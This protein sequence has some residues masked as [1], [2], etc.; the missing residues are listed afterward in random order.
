MTTVDVK[1]TVKLVEGTFTPSEAKDVVS[2]LIKEK[3]N[4]HKIHRLSI[5]EGND[6]SDISYDNSRVMQLIDAQDNFK[7]LCKMVD[8]DGKRMKIHGLLE[9]EIID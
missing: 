5:L 3:L 1:N 6:N 4:F 7:E 9:I 2:S 8:E